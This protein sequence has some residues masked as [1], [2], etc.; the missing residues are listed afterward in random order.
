MNLKGSYRALCNNSKAA[1]LSA[2]EIYNKPQIAYR[3]E[4][5]SILLINAWELLFKAI[6]SK[7]KKR[8]FYPKQRDKLYRSL[9]IQ[10][11]ILRAKEFFPQEIQYEPVYK[12]IDL[13]IT[14]RNNA[15]H[16]YN[17]PGFGIMIYA[18]A[19]TSIINFKD[20]MSSIFNID[21]SSEMSLSLLPLSFGIPPDPIEF[22][23]RSRIDPP[24]N[25]AVAN[26]LRDVTEI[27]KLLES[28]EYDAGRFLTIFKVKL[29][30]IK[31]ISSAD[32]VIP[33]KG[34]TNGSEAGVVEKRIDP[35]ISHPLL[36]KHIKEEIEDEIEG[37]K[38]TDYVFE[39]IAWKYGIKIKPHLCWQPREGG[40]AQYSS[41]VPSIIRKLSRKDIQSAIDEYK[42]FMRE[43]RQRKV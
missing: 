15:I 40:R 20:L 5:F 33:V 34:S 38:F 37:I 3:D 36:R 18:L 14:Y 8:I 39:A 29:Q 43:K 42:K 41:E 4:C 24:R 6:L 27:T 9:S 30:S 22:L 12:N 35:N 11:A 23:Q 25:K 7:N 31:K 32:I 10:D 17:Q 28:Q 13:L 19:Q 21:I 1:I 16:F 2:I 26:Y